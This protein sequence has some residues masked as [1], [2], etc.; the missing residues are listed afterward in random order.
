MAF[1]FRPVEQTMTKTM[2]PLRS[3]KD[4]ISDE[5]AI[6]QIV[7]D[8]SVGINSSGKATNTNLLLP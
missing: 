4:W 2:A 1:S 8:Y 7:V 3:P 5:A 6:S